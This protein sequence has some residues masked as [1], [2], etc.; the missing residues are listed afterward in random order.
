MSY[1]DESYRPTLPQLI[2][3]ALEERL[4]YVNTIMPAKVVEI[5]E[6]TGLLTVEP[7][8]KRK[9][10]HQTDAI[11]L[12]L[13]AGVPL[14]DMRANDAI[15]SMPIAVGD[16]VTLW[17]SQRSLENWKA[18]GRTAVPGTRNIHHIS[19]A[20][21]YPGTYPINKNIKTDRSLLTIKFG[22]SQVKLAKDA[23][24]EVSCKSGKFR[25]TSDGKI[26]AGNGTVELLDLFAQTLAAIKLIQVPTALGPSGVPA[27]VATFTQIEQKLG[28][29]KS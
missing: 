15:I 9:Y 19:D 1:R 11:S 13:I 29:I 14:A 24:V 4:M 23:S 2:Q 22:A 12:P 3:E 5:D 26:Y 16:H 28:S 27:N 10:R 21:A 17:F 7:S 8:F 20:I 18:D 6:T 25:I